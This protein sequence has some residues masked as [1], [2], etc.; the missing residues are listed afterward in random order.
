MIVSPSVPWPLPP[1]WLPDVVQR[2]F[3]RIVLLRNIAREVVKGDQI[4]IF[5]EHPRFLPLV[6]MLKERF[7]SAVVLYCMSDDVPLFF[8]RDPASQRRLEI[9]QRRL[10][11]M[12]DGIV[13]VVPYFV[14]KYLGKAGKPTCILPNGVSVE[15]MLKERFSQ[16]YKLN[17]LPHLRIGFVG[18][19]TDIF[20]WPMMIKL[21]EDH[22]TWSFIFAGTVAANVMDKWEYLREFPNVYYLGA[23][24]YRALGSVLTTF[25]VGLIPFNP[26]N[27]RLKELDDLKLKE[28]MAF[29][30]PVV[31]FNKHTLFSRTRG[32][33][34]Q[35]KTYDEFERAVEGAAATRYDSDLF[36]KRRSLVLDRYDF[37]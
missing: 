33:I 36:D 9:M 27:P 37:W 30:L 24:P 18:A 14:E 20:H 1:K 7:S 25:D 21:V 26:D 11:E 34:W 8:Q 32:V 2:L 22:P 5:V 15:L 28:Y 31:T 13:S 17:E 29:G 6:S 10:I 35:V 23:V 3:F 12:S 4:Y 16:E 19:L